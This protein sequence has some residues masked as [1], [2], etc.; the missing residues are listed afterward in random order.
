MGRGTCPVL[1]G[2]DLRVDAGQRWALVGRNGCGKTTLLRALAGLDRP[3]A[4]TIRWE[5]GRLPAGL[6]RVRTVGILLQQEAPSSFSVDEL[7]TLGL[8]LDGPPSTH[9]DALTST[10]LDALAHRRCATLSGGEAQRSLLARA[11]VGRPR[12]F[13]LDEPTNHLDLARQAA[14]MASLAITSSVAVVLATHDLT[15][16]ASCDRV[17]LLHNGRIELVGA[18]KCSADPRRLGACARRARPKARRS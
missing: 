8:A 16:A 18:P 7:V 3:L 17:M 1:V 2:V 6:A 9:D 11:S 15:V 4:G 14:F 10:Q 12:L 13:R 5:G